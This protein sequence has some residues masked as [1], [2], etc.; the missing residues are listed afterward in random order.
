MKNNCTEFRVKAYGKSELAMLY[1]P[2]MSV[3]EALRTLTRWMMRNES[4]YRELEEMG[5][6]KNCKILTP[7]EVEVITRYLG[8]P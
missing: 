5:Y 2:H 3:R 6:R 1:N 7:R 8:E 4:L